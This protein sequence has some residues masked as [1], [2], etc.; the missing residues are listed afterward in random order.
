MATKGDISTLDVLMYGNKPMVPL[1][2]GYSRYKSDGVVRDTVS[3]G[4]TRQRVKFYGTTHTADVSFRCET[5]A[6]RDFFNMFTERN[7]GRY[8]VC[9]LTADRPLIEP[10]VVQ[11]LDN[12]KESAF[13]NGSVFSTTLEIISVRDTQLDTLMFPLYYTYGDRIMYALSLYDL[14]KGMP[15]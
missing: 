14:T 12:W 6:Q 8:F 3:G 11:A 7:R 9:H 1:M 4:A 13:D 5:F 10:Y 15:V 2:S